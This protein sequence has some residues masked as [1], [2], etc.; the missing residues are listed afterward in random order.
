MC[1]YK[2]VA[3]FCSRLCSCFS[4]NMAAFVEIFMLRN[5]DVISPR[6]SWFLGV[7]EILNYLTVIKGFL[8]R[9]LVAEVE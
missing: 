9:I 2:E 3:L 8:S 1:D 4:A 5:L 7:L 6:C